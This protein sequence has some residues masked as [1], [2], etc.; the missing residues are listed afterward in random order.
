MVN[1]SNNTRFLYPWIYIDMIQRP[2]IGETMSARP[3]LYNMEMTTRNINRKYNRGALKGHIY[4]K[5]L[6]F[7]FAVYF[8]TT[9]RSCVG[10][11]EL[12]YSR[13]L[14]YVS[15]QTWD[16]ME[17]FLFTFPNDCQV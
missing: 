3:I 17:L 7:D 8:K 16:S 15:L 9:R 10:F 4:S 6:H 12:T 5:F 2:M 13:N 14:F 11:N 1:F